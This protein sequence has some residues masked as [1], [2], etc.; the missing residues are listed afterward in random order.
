LP[1]ASVVGEAKGAGSLN[2]GNEAAVENR[3]SARRKRDGLAV[4]CE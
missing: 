4:V 2:A 1:L 3:W